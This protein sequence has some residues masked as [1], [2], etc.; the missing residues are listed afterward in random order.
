VRVSVTDFIAG[1][2]E[3]DE[4]VEIAALLESAGAD[5]ISVSNGQYESGHTTI[6]P[7]S[8]DDG[9]R[10]YLAEMVK[11]KV[12]VPVVTGGV[13]RNPAMADQ[14]I[15]ENKADYVFVG[16]NMIADPEWMLK[17]RQ[18]RPEDIRPCL[19]CNTCI[20][21]SMQSLHMICAVN[22]QAGRETMLK[23]MHRTRQPKNVLVVG[24][25]P[26]GMAAARILASKGHKV[27][28][29]ERE[30]TLGG[31]LESA[32]K[33]PHKQRVGMLQEYLI[34]ELQKTSADIKTGVSVDQSFIQDLK[35]DVLIAATGSTPIPINGLPD[36]GAVIQ[37]IDVLNLD[38][39]FT[40]EKVLV[41]GGGTTGCE[42]A[43]YLADHGN[44]VTLIEAAGQLAIGMENMSRLTLM[45]DIKKAG[46][47]RMTKTSFKGFANHR[48]ELLGP[49]GPVALD[50]DRIVLALGF[51]PNIAVID[52]LGKIVPEVY[53]IGDAEKPR[54][55]EAALYEAEITARQI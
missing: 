16:R 36:N 4:G 9:W 28:L 48:A 38:Q 22:P 35:P 53:V 23:G 43:L 27:T 21:R 5:Y 11:A 6:E 30:A 2:L 1:G 33:P 50:V 46:I 49:D 52:S 18:G 26:A 31:M 37:A 17:V 3:P 44:Q 51:R 32:A 55:I 47:K 8:F 29:A 39:P 40:G 25:G 45:Q 41:V 13:I 15:R 14:I 7:A 24:G 12:S 19:S 42:T 10:V 20:G 54:T 34:R